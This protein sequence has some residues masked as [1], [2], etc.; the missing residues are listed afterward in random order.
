MIWPESASFFRG[1]LI[2]LRLAPVKAPASFTV[3][4]PWLFKTSMIF[5]DKGGR[6][7]VNLSWSIFL[8]RI[9]F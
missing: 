5:S 8:T 4:L 7:A 3:T 2:V 1:S 6:A 9:F